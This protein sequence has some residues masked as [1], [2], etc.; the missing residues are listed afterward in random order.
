VEC[1]ACSN[2][3]FTGRGEVLDRLHEQLRTGPA[4]ALIQTQAISG[5][6][7]IGKTQTAIEYAYRYRG[8]Y[9]AVLWT[10]ADSR[11]AVMAGFVA[12]AT[13]LDL[14][15]KEA[16]DQSI[17]IAAVK[18]WL[19]ANGNW[20][21]IFDNADDP[22][23]IDDFL[24]LNHHGKTLLTSRAQ[25]FDTLSIS[26]PIELEELPPQEAQAF[27]IKRTG[28]GNLNP[29]ERAAVEQLAQELDY[30]PLALEQAAAYL[31]AKQT[32]FQDYLASY[33]EHGLKLLERAKPVTGKYPKSVATT[34]LLNVEQVEKE[35]AAA[36]D[37][38]C[39]SAFLHP[40]NIPLELLIDGTSEL[41]PTLSAALANAKQDPLVLDEVLEP[42]TRYSLIRRN[43]EAQTCDIHRLVQE[44]IKDRLDEATQRLWAERVVRAVNA[45]FPTVEVSSWPQCERL[46]PHALVCAKLLKGW[47]LRSLEAARL[48]NQTGFYL[49]ERAYYTQTESLYRKALEIVENIVGPEHLVTATALNSLAELYYA[50]GRYN[51]AESLHKRALTIREKALGPEHHDVAI[52]LNNLAEMYRIQGRYADAE[53]FHQQALK[54]RDKTFGP[55]HP[56]V[57]QNINNLAGLYFDQKRY[58]E[59]D[60]LYQCKQEQLEKEQEPNRYYLGVLLYNRAVL[61]N[62]QEKY[63]EAE[64][65]FQRSLEIME[66]LL[67]P[68]HLRI[69]T[70][71]KNYAD[72]LRATHREAE[73][74]K[75][76]ARA[77]MI[78][79]KYVQENQKT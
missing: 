28:R 74:E 67:G 8:D 43:L 53:L 59:A 4:A 57:V 33:R 55:D 19:E 37:V 2:P 32:R 12:I 44:V 45:A 63:A 72:L 9:Q 76:E 70:I 60:H 14:P 3:F 23:V 54:V 35:S 31:V 16:Q 18:R 75:L 51:E 73:A 10:A 69:A 61:Y 52:S 47:S 11:E 34:W 27:L 78:R 68:E 15:Q 58:D 38:L 36:A 65:L 42:L 5:L 24:P 77:R 40:D 71:L 46:I 25:L 29:V 49:H 41:G 64:S 62:T 20:L 7:G 6:G 1:A 56:Q 48:L 13:L 66:T 26:S 30:L 79:E 22:Q 39:F 17:A 50:Q 21:F